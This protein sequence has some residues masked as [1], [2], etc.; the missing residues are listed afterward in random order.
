MRVSRLSHPFRRF[1]ACRPVLLALVL[2]LACPAGL[3]AYQLKY[4]EELYRLYHQHLYAQNFD[5]TENIHYL[6]SCL[7]ADFANPLNALARI[8]DKKE[9][10]KYRA[11]FDMHINLKMVES[12]LQLASRYNKQDAFFYNAPW[13][14]LNLEGLDLAEQLMKTA[15][16]YWKDAVDCARRTEKFRWNRLE[17]LESWEDEAWRINNGE[18]DYL[19]IIDRHLGR[20]AQVRQEFRNMDAT[21][22]PFA[23]NP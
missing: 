5:I 13:Q 14:E 10:E 23:D 1:P 16:V 15:L 4:K 2:T 20:I 7:K 3:G 12:Y 18:L 17:E 21:T 22:Y 11:L 19:K 8:Q 6:E 9:W